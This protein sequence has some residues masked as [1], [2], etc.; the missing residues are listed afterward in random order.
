MPSAIEMLNRKLARGSLEY[1]GEVW[2]GD[3]NVEVDSMWKF[4]KEEM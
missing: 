4:H 2:A 1:P 3:K